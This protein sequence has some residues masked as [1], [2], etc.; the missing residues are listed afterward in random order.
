MVGKN[1]NV[2]KEITAAAK[3]NIE[4]ALGKSVDLYLKVRVEKKKG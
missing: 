3:S 1:G 2:I 4:R